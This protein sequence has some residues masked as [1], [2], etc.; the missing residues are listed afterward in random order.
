M[1]Q[2]NFIAEAR[3]NASNWARNLLATPSDRWVILDTETTGLDSTAEVIQIGVIDGSGK[4]LMDNVLCKPLKPIPASATAIHHISNGM[5]QNA[6]PFQT[7]WDTLTQI[8]NGKIVVVFNAEYDRRLLIQSAVHLPNPK[9]FRPVRWDCAMIKHAEWVG[10]WDDYH[11]SF[12][13]QKLQGGDHS[14]LGDCLAT[15]DVIK[16]IAGKQ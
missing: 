10:E 11:H 5:V 15:L 12:R 14:A 13:W 6:A 8:A 16:K 3:R 9:P 4:I 2:N 7:A 1:V